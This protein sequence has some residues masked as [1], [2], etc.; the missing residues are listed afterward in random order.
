MTHAKFRSA[1]RVIPPSDVTKPCVLIVDD[2]ASNLVS[3]EALLADMD[4]TPIRAESGNE[5]LR[6]LLKREYALMLLDVQMPGMDGYEVAAYS[7]ENPATRDVPIVFLTAMHENPDNTLRGY[8]SGAV[9]FLYKPIVPQIL[10]SK[11]KVFLE[12]YKNRRALEEEVEAHR[13]TLV[14]LESANAALRHF[15]YAASHDLHA[16]LRV[17]KGYLE[18]LSEEHGADLSAE[19]KL[20]VDRSIE[21]SDRM[22]RLLDALLVY[23]RLQTPQALEDVDCGAVLG[24]V[25][26]DLGELI[27]VAGASVAAGTLPKVR[28]DPGRLYQLFLNLVGNAIK[29]RHPERAPT[30]RVDATGRGGEFTFA[31]KDN[32]LGIDAVHHESVFD[33]F[34]RLRGANTHE[35]SGLGL[36]ICRQIVQQLGGRIWVE[37]VLGQGATLYFTLPRAGSGARPAV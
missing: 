24:Q 11:V 18:S 37:S 26:T 2:V 19:A 32:G 21:A 15:T 20:Y 17:T 16:P 31:I 27:E 10:R 34:R 30:V 36:T 5:A 29:Y 7:R 23:A 25:L 35:G 28:A 13:T 33:A 22:V 14:E 4:C 12:L 1:P 3:L 9:D 6:Q 8:G